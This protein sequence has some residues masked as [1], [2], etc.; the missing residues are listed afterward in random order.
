MSLFCTGLLIKEMLR[1]ASTDLQYSAMLEKTIGVLFY[2][3][4]HRGAGL[5]YVSNKAKYMLFPSTEVQELDSS[6]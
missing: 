4:P 1:M 6:E 2:S 5:A 3:V